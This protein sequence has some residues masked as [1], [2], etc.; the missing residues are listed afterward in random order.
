V[1][2]D[3]LPD[4]GKDKFPICVTDIFGANTGQLDLHLGTSINSDLAIDT[5]LEDI[6]RVLLYTVPLDYRVVDPVDNLQQDK[7]ILEV[8]VQVVNKHAFNAERV[9]PKSE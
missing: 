3:K 5:L 4:D 9:D 6:V 2:S 7:T 1:E 8:I